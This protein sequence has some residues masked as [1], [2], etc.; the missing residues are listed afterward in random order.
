MQLEKVIDDFRQRK[1]QIDLLEMELIQ[2]KPGGD[3]IVYKGKGY[4]RQTEDDVL[5]FRLYADEARNT[6]IAKSINTWHA[7][8]PGRLYVETD[9]YTLKGLASDGTSWTAEQVLPQEDWLASHDKPIAHG[10]LRSCIRSQDRTMPR[11]L[12]LYFFEKADLPCLLPTISFPAQGC[13]FEV[14]HEDDI[15]AIRVKSEQPLPEHFDTRIEGALR[16]LLAQSVQTRVRVQGHQFEL[17]SGSARSVRTALGPPI[18]RGS[19]AF[20]D[21]SWQLFDCYLGYI[22]K[23]TK[24]AYW[25][26]ISNH[27]HNALE[28]SSNSIDAWAIGLG[29]AV[30]GIA[31]LLP[32]KMPVD[33][34]AKMKDLQK[35]I[36]KQVAGSD[37]HKEY[38][39]RVQGLVAGLTAVRAVDKMQWLV[40]QGGTLETH[41]QAWKD[42]RNRNVHPIGKIDVASLDYQRLIDELHKVSVLLY[43][44]VF[45][46]IGYSG[47]YTDYG[48]H[49][50]P[51]A[52]YPPPVPAGEEPVEAPAGGNDK[53]E[54]GEGVASSNSL[55]ARFVQFVTKLRRLFPCW[56]AAGSVRS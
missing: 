7:I 23:E 52:E 38:S 39:G 24:A 43:H 9:Y 41:V 12:G 1:L 28:A 21:N 3:A 33:Q 19:S 29:V 53:A 34:K 22:T 13:T 26:P 56:R 37:T 46:I 48:A 18:S 6:D 42:L 25:N 49:G 16:F 55:T 4:I 54:S 17:F 36:T 10:K 47:P 45:H 31:N 2:N 44:I 50:F 30:E 11:A 14:E 35:F 40:K 5:T 15:F 8:K 51:K 32:Y 20:M 27:V